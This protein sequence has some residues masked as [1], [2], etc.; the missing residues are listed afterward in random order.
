M[1]LP[2]GEAAQCS[3]AGK[4]FVVSASSIP[5]ISEAISFAEVLKQ[6]RPAG[7]RSTCKLRNIGSAALGW[8]SAVQQ[9]GCCGT[10]QKITRH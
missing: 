10:S 7:S 8:R 4:G 6:V 9:A 1:Q 2:K 5:G 3:A